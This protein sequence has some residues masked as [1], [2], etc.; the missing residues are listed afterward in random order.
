MTAIAGM[1]AEQHADEAQ[2]LVEAAKEDVRAAQ[3]A[4][5]SEQGLAQERAHTAFAAAGVHVG[6]AQ[7][8]Y[9]RQ[10]ANRLAGR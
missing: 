5:P 1:T 4:S 6:L 10:I 2:R 8:A 3:G 7:A 9:L